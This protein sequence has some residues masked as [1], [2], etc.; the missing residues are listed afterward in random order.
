MAK[1]Y[2]VY[3]QRGSYDTSAVTAYI[4]IQAATV[5]DAKKGIIAAQFPINAMYDKQTQLTRAEK[6]RD[7]L[8]KI[9]EMTNDLEKDQSI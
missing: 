2:E 3:T 8:N 9:V 5:D 6:F 7:Y 1:L 4:L